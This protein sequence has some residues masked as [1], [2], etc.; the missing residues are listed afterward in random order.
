MSENSIVR[1]VKVARLP[2][3]FR[4]VRRKLHGVLT[5]TRS[6]LEQ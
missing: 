6:Y 3:Y 1:L 5:R 4:H 2:A